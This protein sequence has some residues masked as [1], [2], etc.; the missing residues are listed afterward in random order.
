MRRTLTNTSLIESEAVPFTLTSIFPLVITM[1]KS[2]LTQKKVT[3][4]WNGLV[5]R[6]WQTLRERRRSTPYFQDLICLFS[7]T[8]KILKGVFDRLRRVL[9]C[10]VFRSC[11]REF[12]N[13]R[14]K[15]SL[16]KR[17]APRGRMS[18][19]EMARFDCL[20]IASLSLTSVF[21]AGAL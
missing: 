4:S 3:L 11:C 9:L 15:G 19:L 8:S 1:M 20:I 13:F 7:Q 16:L 5:L 2:F 10:P 6:Y 14:V 12:L 17:R 21:K 18:T